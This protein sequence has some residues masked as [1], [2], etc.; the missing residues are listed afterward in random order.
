MLNR[1]DRAILRGGG[2]AEDV[3]PHVAEQR[4]AE[5]RLQIVRVGDGPVEG[6]SDQRDADA[7]QQ[8]EQGR[9]G[10]ITQR[11]GRGRAA[12][13][14]RRWSIGMGAMALALARRPAPLPD[15]RP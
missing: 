6:I 11:L 15:W 4:K 1:L 14:T 5:G 12:G 2:R 13:G 9:E 7:Q 8:A 3:R 10:R